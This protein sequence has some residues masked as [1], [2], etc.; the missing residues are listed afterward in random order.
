MILGNTRHVFQRIFLRFLQ[1]FHQR[2][3][4]AHTQLELR[5]PKRFKG[6]NLKMRNQRRLGA[7]KLIARALLYIHSKRSYAGR[8][9]RIR[10]DLLGA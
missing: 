7:C 3:C 4:C 6:L 9:L 8:K 1:V 10:D 5:D 2:S